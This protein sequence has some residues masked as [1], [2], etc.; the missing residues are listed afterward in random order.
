MR[1]PHCVSKPHMQGFTPQDAALQGFEKSDWLVGHREGEHENEETHGRVGQING[2]GAC[3]QPVLVI[4]HVKALDC[5]A[6]ILA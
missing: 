3:R 5:M 1:G 6:A 4:P 2:Y